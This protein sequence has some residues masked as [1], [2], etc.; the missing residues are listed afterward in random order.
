MHFDANLIKIEWR[1]IFKEFKT[2][3]K[4]AVIVNEVLTISNYID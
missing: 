3:V 4:N 1:Q 2:A